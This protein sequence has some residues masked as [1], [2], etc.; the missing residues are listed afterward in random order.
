MRDGIT[1]KKPN[2]FATIGFIEAAKTFP[3]FWKNK[4][5]KKSGMIREPIP[6][7]S[8]IKPRTKPRIVNINKIAIKM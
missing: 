3:I 8:F 1:A 7:I 4:T 5:D 6:K 2:M